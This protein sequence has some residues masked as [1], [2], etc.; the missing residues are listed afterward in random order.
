MFFDDWQEILRTLVIGALAYVVLVFLLRV[1]GKHTLSKW[2]AFDFVVTGQIGAVVLE[3]D[4]SFSIVKDPV[5]GT[6]ST[7]S[8]VA[9]AERMP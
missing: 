9:D 6:G 7:L 4:G 2:N 8:D 1:S 3:A 5:R